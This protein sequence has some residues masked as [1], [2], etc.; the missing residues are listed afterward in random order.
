MII[1]NY[2]NLAG[3]PMVL[4]IDEENNKSESMPK[5]EYDRREAEQSTPM[6]TDAPKS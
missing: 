2:E 5:S 3:E 4:I 6:V 1:T